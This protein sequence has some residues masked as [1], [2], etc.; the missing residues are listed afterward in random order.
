LFLQTFSSETTPMKLSV[1]RL[2]TTPAA[3]QFEGSSAW[4]RAALHPE[5]NLPQEL[6]EP[7]RF[8]LQAYRMGDDVYI[9]GEVRGSVELECS[10]CLARYRHALHEPFRLVLEPAGDRVPADPEG[11]EALARDGVCLGEDLEAGWYRGS[12]IHL[13]ALALEVVSLALPIQP[14][15]REDCPGLCPI[16]GIDL[17]TERCDCRATPAHSPFAVLATLRG[18]GTSEAPGGRS[19]VRNPKK[20]GKN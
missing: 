18:G 2:T 9:E 14:R 7:I 19:S 1:D 8:G 4:W 17:G 16:C 15:C 5:R 11:A 6:A 12:E 3:F 13:G 10:R 20:R